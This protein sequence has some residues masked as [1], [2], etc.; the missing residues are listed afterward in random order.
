[1]NWITNNISEFLKETLQSFV[2][3]ISD[4]MN[5]LFSFA[6]TAG[7]STEVNGA[8]AVTTGIAITLVLLMCLKQIFAIYVME[9]EGDADANPLQLIVKASQAIA[10]ISCNAYVFNL[11]MRLANAFSDEVTG[12]VDVQGIVPLVAQIITSITSGMIAL[13]V[14]LILLLILVIIMGIKAGIRGAELALMKILFPIFCVDLLSVNREKWSSFIASY[15]VTFFGYT[16]EIFCIKM[17]ITNFSGGT[18]LSGYV[19]SVAWM[20]MAI[21][22]PEWLQKYTYTSGLKG[23]IGGGARNMAMLVRFK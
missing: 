2:D 9:T 10:L 8:C 17:F 19:V 11:L 6:A 18:S 22:T 1:M 21:K 12:G 14:F 23:I 4:G 3:F 15:L 20:Y 5:A 16:L 13:P 7:E